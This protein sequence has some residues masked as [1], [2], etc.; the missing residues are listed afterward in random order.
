MTLSVVKIG[1]VW[2]Y[3][4]ESFGAKL[5]G[6]EQTL[7]LAG[8][9]DLAVEVDLPILCNSVLGNFLSN[10]IKFSPRE[11]TIRMQ[12][13]LADDFVRIAVFDEGPGLPTDVILKGPDD[14]DRRSGRGTEDELGSG[15]GLQIAALCAAR[16]K[17]RIEFQETVSGG[18][19]S[20]VL[21]LV[22]QE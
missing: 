16:M 6:K 13:E 14:P 22:N 18:A 2:E 11:G 1:D 15:Y 12:A 10:A 19:V 7:Q 5:A 3:T 4:R 8:D 21:P 17:G 9:V 20:V